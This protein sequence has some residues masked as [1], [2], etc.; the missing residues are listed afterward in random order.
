MDMYTDDMGFKYQE[1]VHDLK[2]QIFSFTKFPF[3]FSKQTI[4]PLSCAGGNEV[5]DS[6]RA[7]STQAAIKIL[8]PAGVSEVRLLK[9]PRDI[10]RYCC[11]Y[12]ARKTRRRF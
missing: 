7:H 12:F 11:F 9:H 4:I 10:A 5:I 2:V 1:F 3:S 8:I 6:Q